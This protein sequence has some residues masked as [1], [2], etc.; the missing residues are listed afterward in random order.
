MPYDHNNDWVDPN[1]DPYSLSKKYWGP[2]QRKPFTDPDKE[3]RQRWK[4]DEEKAQE[5][6]PTEPPN[7][8][9]PPEGME[10]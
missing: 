6:Y 8:P 5:N 7:H 4:S 3:L 10:K 2:A 9:E 1:H